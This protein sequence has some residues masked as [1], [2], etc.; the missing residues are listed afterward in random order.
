[1]ATYN[2]DTDRS[3]IYRRVPAVQ[4]EG[5]TRSILRGCFLFM[6]GGRYMQWYAVFA[7]IELARNI[8]KC[9]ILSKSSPILYNVYFFLL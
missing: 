7:Y 9:G 2:K 5:F 4:V 6:S 3:S 1:M 8:G